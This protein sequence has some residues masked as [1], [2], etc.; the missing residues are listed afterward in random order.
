MKRH[1]GRLPGT[2]VDLL[3]LH[4]GQTPPW[5]S[6]GAVDRAR[7]DLAQA[8]ADAV[9]YQRDLP[10]RVGTYLERYPW[11]SS[12]EE[13]RLSFPSVLS[14]KVQVR[15]PFLRVEMARQSVLVDRSGIV[16][17]WE[18]YRKE[19][20]SV[21]A[22]RGIEGD[23]PGAGRP[24]QDRKAK[25]ALDLLRRVELFL[26]VGGE[27]PLPVVRVD[28]DHLEES[29]TLEPDI[30]LWVKSSPSLPIR[31]SYGSQPGRIPIEVQVE[32]LRHHLEVDPHLDLPKEYIDLRAGAIR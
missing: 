6:P 16:L 3:S 5:L 25:A 9:V 21:P 12:V 32:S 23:P 24:W 29:G 18:D 1:L 27:G 14:V 26:G 13:V 28:V 30:K 17:S 20:L 7:R 19:S 22:C 4:F 31:F 8:F 11:I 2:R 15:Q 10:K